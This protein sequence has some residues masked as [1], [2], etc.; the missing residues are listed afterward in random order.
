ML[1]RLNHIAIALNNLDDGIN[2]YKGIFGASISDRVALPEH[3]VTT[4]FVKLKNT[5]IELLEP[6]GKNSPISN[7]LIKNPSGGIHHLCYEVNDINKS[8]EKLK[9]K[10]YTVLGSGIPRKGAHGK[11]VIFLHPKQ[12]IGTLIELEEVK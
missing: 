3:G 6:L 12:F 10:G 9:R 2:I 5:N 1:K 4:I 11:P 8:I 7:F